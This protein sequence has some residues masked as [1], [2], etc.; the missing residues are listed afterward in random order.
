MAD[1][2][3]MLEEKLIVSEGEQYWL[4]DGED[5]EDLERELREELR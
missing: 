1:L 3:L 4:R 2:Q 5:F